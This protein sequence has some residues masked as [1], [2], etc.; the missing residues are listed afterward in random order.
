MSAQICLIVGGKRKGENVVD[1]AMIKFKKKM[2]LAEVVTEKK[3]ETIT[4]DK[5]PNKNTPVGAAG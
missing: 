4:V 2:K 5:K 3:L 1:G